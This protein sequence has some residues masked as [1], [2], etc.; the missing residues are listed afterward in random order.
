MQRNLATFENAMRVAAQRMSEL[1]R[2]QAVRKVEGCYQVEDYD[3]DRK[4]GP[5]VAIHTTGEGLEA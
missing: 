5:I 2:D 4:C 1:G 3:P